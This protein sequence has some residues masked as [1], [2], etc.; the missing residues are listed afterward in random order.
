MQFAD[1][2]AMVTVAMDTTP[3]HAVSDIWRPT[4]MTVTPGVPR[5]GKWDV[6]YNTIFEKRKYSVIK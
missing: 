4:T 1:I 5:P 6:P 3:S 2:V